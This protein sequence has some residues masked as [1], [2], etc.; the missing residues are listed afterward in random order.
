MRGNE[1]VKGDEYNQMLTT[2]N[3]KCSSHGKV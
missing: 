1:A 3:H 2:V